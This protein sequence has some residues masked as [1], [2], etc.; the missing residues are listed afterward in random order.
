MTKLLQYLLAGMCLAALAPAQTGARGARVV[1][2]H[3]TPE[4][5]ASPSSGAHNVGFRVSTLGGI[6]VALWYPTVAAPVS[7]Y[8]AGST[9]SGMVAV[10]AVPKTGARYP[11]LVL[12]HGLGSCGIQSIFITEEVARRGL[13]VAAPDHSDA[14][15]ASD[16]SFGTVSPAPKA[17][18]SFYNPF[19]WTDQSYVHRKNELTAMLN[20]LLADAQFAPV[21]DTARI[22]IAGHS[23]GGYAALGMAGGWTSW[24]DSR[25]KAALLFSP[26]LQPFLLKNRLK[27]GVFIP[28]MYQTGTVDYTM[29]PAILRAGGAYDL[30]NPPKYVVE[31]TNQGHTDWTNF[32]CGSWRTVSSCL[33]NVPNAQAVNN[34]THRFLAETL[35]A[36]K[37]ALSTTVPSD[38]PPV[39]VNLY[40]A[41]EN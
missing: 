34:F 14:T 16:G 21:I 39:T 40:K 12:S 31:F 7:H 35:R 18:T 1:R 26:Y 27:D 2:L 37:T 30:S 10:S 36:D 33:E 4:N 20:A 11:L 38:V 28:V 6:R 8:Y 15:C 24:K 17:D 41:Q 22:A 29:A 32:L 9:L 5:M 13:V 3:P 25:L 19:A 23:V